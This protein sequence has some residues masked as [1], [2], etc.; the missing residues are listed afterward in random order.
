[1]IKNKIESAM[2]L[3]LQNSAYHCFYF[4]VVRG[5]YQSEEGLA[6]LKMPL[7]NLLGQDRSQQV[8]S[9]ARN[10]YFCKTRNSY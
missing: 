2:I 8:S 6:F 9:T 1:M 5:I 4:T 10:H 7:K 3:P